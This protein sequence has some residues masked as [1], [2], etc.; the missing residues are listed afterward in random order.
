[1]K[2]I[3][4]NPTETAFATNGIGILNDAISCQVVREKNG[5]YEVTLKYPVTGVH[6]ESI[7]ER[8]ILMVK[9]DPQRSPQPFRVYH[10]GPAVGGVATFS[11]RHLAYDLLGIP[12]APFSVQGISAAL[13]ALAASA[14]V[15][16]PFTFSTDKN[17]A[18]TMTVRLPTPIWNLL[19]GMEG[20]LLDVFGGEY[21]FDRFEVKLLSRLGADR[22]V[23]I[24]YGKNLT[25]LE[26]DRNVANCYTGVYPYWQGRDEV[27]VELPERV[28]AASGDYGYTRIMTLDLSGEWD[29]APTAEQ[30]RERTRRYMS[31][32]SI[33]VP[34]VSWKIEFVQLEQTEEYRWMGQAEQV[35]LGD[36]VHVYFPQIDV[37]ASARVFAYAYD[38]ILERYDDVTLGSVKDN[39]AKTI[40]Q[41]KKATMKAQ[42]AVAALDR[43]LD[44]KG[45]FDRLTNN[46]KY[47][48]IFIEG[49]TYYFN[50]EYIRGKFISA[51]NIDLDGK[52]RVMGGGMEGGWLGYMAGSSD[53][54]TT[55]GIGMSD[56]TGI[57][58]FM[59]TNG[60][61]KLLSAAKAFYMTPQGP[62]VLVNDLLV[63]GNIRY[64]GQLIYEPE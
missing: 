34:K 31:D 62:A 24:R 10:V 37:D 50:G 25:T 60:G 21:D 27:L 55:H 53:G 61:V 14:A 8:S 11:A 49:D 47:Q 54:D 12:A 22:G 30:L 20:S 48:G 64:T 45:I 58:S 39:I 9:P 63:R 15:D 51:E 13:E 32:N 43:S 28:I 29:E 44:Q 46:G 59:V 35:L 1:M 33:G 56:T 2:P 52:F 17:T 3:L 38:A 23:S 26:Q 5:Q 16:C 4:Y 42:E 18:S 36:T 7:V 41:Q 6:F 19:G 57:N 40:A